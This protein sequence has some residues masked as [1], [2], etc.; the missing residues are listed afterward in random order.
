[1]IVGNRCVAWLIPC[2]DHPTLPFR[3]WVSVLDKEFMDSSMY[4]AEFAPLE[5]AK[6]EIEQWW[7]YARRGEV[8]PEQHCYCSHC[9]VY[10]VQHCHCSH[11]LDDT[12]DATDEDD[13]DALDYDDGRSRERERD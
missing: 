2:D 9:G 6:H 10:P 7:E 13:F 11:C 12:T 1:M 4:A 5:F 3:V 8:Y